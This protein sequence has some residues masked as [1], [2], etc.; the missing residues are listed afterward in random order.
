LA[1]DE[2]IMPRF[3]ITPTQMGLV[4]SAFL[5]AYTIGMVPGGLAIDRFGPRLALMG[6]LL[7]TGLFGAL[8]GAV[9]FAVGPAGPLWV[10]LLL[11]R[12]LMGFCTAPLH[13]G[14]ARTVG[15]WVPG[16]RQ[17][18]AN[19]LAV[20]AALVGVASTYKL[21]GWLIDRFDWPVAFMVT[22]GA[23]IIL[24]LVWG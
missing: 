24:G 5:L 15:F 10:S 4:Y 18:L 16:P 23:T 19:G 1:A 14:C 2:R 21:F 17:G 22:G 20:G 12:S 3:G 6:M 9:G 13:P 7:L 11:V 8:T